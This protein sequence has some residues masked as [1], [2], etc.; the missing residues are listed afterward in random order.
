MLIFSILQS[1]NTERK[2]G[3]KQGSTI[4]CLQE[5]H[6]TGKDK[7]T[8]SKWVEK[9]IKKMESESKKEE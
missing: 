5:M 2:A 3:L 1:K 4:Y 6:L 9:A 8:L 7:Q